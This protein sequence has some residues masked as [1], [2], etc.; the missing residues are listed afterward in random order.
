MA[1]EKC[2]KRQAAHDQP[3]AEGSHEVNLTDIQVHDQPLAEGSYEPNLTDIEALKC[4][5]AY[6][7]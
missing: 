5:V 2:I 6:S 4:A 3:L 1:R 7:L